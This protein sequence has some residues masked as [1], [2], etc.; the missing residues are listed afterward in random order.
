MFEHLNKTLIRWLDRDI[1]DG[2]KIR[3]IQRLH[4]T[5]NKNGELRFCVN[6]KTDKDVHMMMYSSH[7][8]VLDG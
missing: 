5:F 7:E 8:I 6:V 1:E 2:E 4:T 3:R